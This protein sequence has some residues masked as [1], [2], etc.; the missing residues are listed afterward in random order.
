MAGKGKW[1]ISLHNSKESNKVFGDKLRCWKFP[2][3]GPFLNEDLPFIYLFPL[4]HVQTNPCKGG[5]E[6][7]TSLLLFQP[8]PRGQDGEVLQ[9]H[10][11][12]TASTCSLPLDFSVENLSLMFPEV[13]VFWMPVWGHCS[14]VNCKVCMWCKNKER[15]L[16]FLYFI[17]RAWL[18]WSSKLLRKWKMSANFCQL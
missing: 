9:P 6:S 3:S 17:L 4:I 14:F 2:F 8:L 11:W 5:G 13:P 10:L 12:L 15:S 7:E 1:S 16:F 18:W